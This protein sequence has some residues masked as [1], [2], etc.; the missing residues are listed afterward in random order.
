MNAGSDSEVRMRVVLKVNGSLF[1]VDVP[2]G[3]VLLDTLRGLG[4]RGVKD[5][6]R[7]SDCGSC[8]VILDGKPVASCSVLTGQA[9]GCSITTI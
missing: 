8:T 7:A 9:D 3:E 4:F 5:G 1:E 6:C 2:P